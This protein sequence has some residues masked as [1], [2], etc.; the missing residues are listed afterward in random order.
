MWRS[1]R[2]IVFGTYNNIIPNA[3][4]INVALMAFILLLIHERLT[5][6]SIPD[7]FFMI[8]KETLLSD[9]IPFCLFFLLPYWVPSRFSL[10]CIKC[11]WYIKNWD[12]FPPL[13]VNCF[14]WG[15]LHLWAHDQ[16]S[17]LVICLSVAWGMKLANAF[18]NLHYGERYLNWP[19]SNITQRWNKFSK[20][21]VIDVFLN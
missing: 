16:S 6:C 11:N 20:V 21:T 18:G 8:W 5:Y 19:E 10:A 13:E 7:S 2:I 1:C 9:V 12:A 3:C 4:K 14:A 17:R 15:S